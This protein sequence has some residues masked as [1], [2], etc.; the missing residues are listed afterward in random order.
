[1]KAPPPGSPRLSWTG[2]TARAGAERR[3]KVRLESNRA[4]WSPVTVIY[5]PMKGN[6]GPGC[7]V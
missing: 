3:V 5:A 6:N 2:R 7:G 4:A 1:M